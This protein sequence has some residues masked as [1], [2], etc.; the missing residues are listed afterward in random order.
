MNLTVRIAGAFILF[1]TVI[2]YGQK[3]SDNVS[4]EI[5]KCIDTKLPA[6]S[7]NANLKDS[8]NACFGKGLATDINGLLKEYKMKGNSITVEQ[9]RE[10]RARLRRK[11][12]QDCETF[13]KIIS[14]TDHPSKGL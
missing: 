5:C 10:V 4:R 3:S 8:V 9:I 14:T 13:K 11:L 6:I 12:E 7:E 2:S 1:T